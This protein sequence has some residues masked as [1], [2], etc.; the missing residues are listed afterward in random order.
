MVFSYMNDEML[1]NINPNLTGVAPLPLGPTGL[2]GNELNC[3]MMGINSQ[4]KDKRVRDAA[5][6]YI[7]FWGSEEAIKIRCKYY[8]ESGWPGPF[9]VHQ[10]VWLLQYSIKCRAGRQPD[11]ARPAGQAPWPQLQN[12]CRDDPPLDAA[13]LGDKVNLQKSWIRP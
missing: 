10:E 11:E 12:I 3:A 13:W 8:V 5:W 2:R 7:K 9:E 6:E 1:A 4:V